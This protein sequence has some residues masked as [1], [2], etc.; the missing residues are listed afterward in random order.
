[1]IG[2]AFVERAGDRALRPSC[3]RSRRARHRLARVPPRPSAHALGG[4]AGI[5]VWG[6]IEL[7]WRVRDKVVRADGTP[8]D[9]MLHHRHQ[10]QDHHHA[11]DGDDARRGRAARGAGRQ[12]RRAGAR[13]RARSGRVR[14]ARRR[15]VEPPA[16]VTGSGCGGHPRADRA[17]R[18]RVPEPRRRPPRLARVARGVPRCEGPRLRQHPRRLRLQ[19]GG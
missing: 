5:A 18:E 1:M 8:A 7:A 6:D 15:A 17:A 11:A 12:H 16:L 3:S 13:C 10:R 14:R 2:A 19:Q 9:W 4:G